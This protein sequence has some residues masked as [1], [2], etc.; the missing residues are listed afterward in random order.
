MR[1]LGG[2]VATALVLAACSSSESAPGPVADAGPAPSD[3][4]QACTRGAKSA[5][6]PAT[7]NG[8][9]ELCSRSYADVV[10]PMA[11]NAMSAQDDGFGVPN[12]HHGPARAL[13]DGVRGLMLDL[14]YFDPDT[15]Q[16]D[17]GRVAGRS[18]MDQVYLCHGPCSFGKVRLLDGLCPITSFLDANPGEIVSIIFE[19]YVDDADT[20]AVLE[21]A[22]LAE[23]AYVHSAGTPW[24]TLGELASTNKRLVVFLEKG[25]GKPPYLMPAY[26]GNLWDTPYSFETQADFTC[27]L[28]RGV[29]GSPLF[30]VNHWL[31]RPLADVAFAQEVNV[32]SVLGRRVEECA[33][34]AGRPPTFVAVD[35]YDV[36]DLFKVVKKANGL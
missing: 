10:T 20:A 31:G 8:A 6:K 36:G 30:L 33:S 5:D 25:G 1:V 28:G 19:T 29:A 22:G 4:P 3:L 2:I 26:E 27:A 34:A 15:N 9:A 11:H 32:A 7:C 17:G 13:A 35:F 23:Y 16:T 24:P 14:H 21:A 18:A 12:Q